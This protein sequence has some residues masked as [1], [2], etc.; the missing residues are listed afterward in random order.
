MNFCFLPRTALANGVHSSRK[1]FAL[2]EQILSLMCGP[3]LKRETKR[4]LVDLLFLKVLS[5]H[6]KTVY[7]KYF[8]SG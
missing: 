7:Q 4:K 1:E 8:G 3:L 6:L 5:S 2:K